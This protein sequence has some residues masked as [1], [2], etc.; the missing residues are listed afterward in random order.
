[1]HPLRVFLWLSFALLALAACGGGGGGGSGSASGPT[2]SMASQTVLIGRQLRARPTVS[3]AAGGVLTFSISGK[4]AW[5][6]FQSTTGEISGTPGAADAGT[7]E[8]IRIGVSDGQ[9]QSS[10][11]FS[12]TVTASAPGR[13]TL[14][15]DAPANR[16]DGTPLTDLSGFRVYY[17]SSADDLRYVVVVQDPG[18]RSA[19]VANLTPGTW[20]F[21]VTAYDALGIESHPSNTVSKTIA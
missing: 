8:N 18:A 13:A 20:Y 19:L 3:G 10:V 9:R 12:I 11:A 21:V 5:L 17:G 6:G 7:F 15:F 16:L 1:M 4:P 2:I 14:S